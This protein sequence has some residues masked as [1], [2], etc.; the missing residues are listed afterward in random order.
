VEGKSL[1][2]DATAKDGRV[3]FDVIVEGG[4]GILAFQDEGGS[5]HFLRSERP[6]ECRGVVENEPLDD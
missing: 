3:V 5:A 1:H 6:L 4:A 2:L